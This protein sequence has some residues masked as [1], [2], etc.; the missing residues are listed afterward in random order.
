MKILVTGGAGYIGS[1]ASEQLCKA[2]YERVLAPALASFAQDAVIGDR[3]IQAVTQEPHIIEPFRDD[4]HQL[5]FA[6]HVV[7]KQQQHHLH[8]HHWIF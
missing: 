5:S 2:G 8:D 7:Q 4:S 3:V 1:I 6:T